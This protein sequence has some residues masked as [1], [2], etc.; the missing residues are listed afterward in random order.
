[1]KIS[2]I[3]FNL[4]K[5]GKKQE[6]LTTKP[7]ITFEGNKNEAAKKAGAILGIPLVLT[8]L[9]GC[10]GGGANQPS[11]A[12]TSTAT[13][14]NETQDVNTNTSKEDEATSLGNKYD[15]MKTNGA[16]LLTADGKIILSDVGFHS[17]PISEFYLT[18]VVGQQKLHP[19][20]D[21]TRNDEGTI[22]VTISNKETN[23]DNESG[24]TLNEIIE[25]VYSEALSQYKDEQERATIKNK[26][27]DE[28]I[29]ANPSLSAYI[30]EELGRDVESYEEIGN[31]D[32]YKG[33]SSVDEYLDTRLLTMPTTIVYQKQGVETKETDYSTSFTNYT[34]KTQIAS[35][36]KDSDDLL[37]GEYKSF[38]D[39]VYGVY[40]KDISNEA[41]R[42]IVYAIVNSPANAYEFEYALDQMN[43]NEIIRTGNITDINRTLDENTN[44]LMVGLEMPNITTLRVNSKNADNNKVNKNAIIYQI[45]PAALTEGEND[46]VITLTDLTGDK[47]LSGDVFALKDVLQFYSSPDGNGRFAYIEDGKTILNDDVNYVEEFANQIMKQVVYA[48]IDLFATPYAIGDKVYEYGVFDV[49]KGYDTKDKS[50]DEIIKNSTIN[51]SRMNKFSFIDENGEMKYENGT[52]LNLPQFNYRLNLCAPKATTPTPVPTTE[53]TTVPTTEPTTVPTTEPTTC[54]TTEPTTCPTTEPTTCPTTEPTTCP[55]TEPTTC[56][57]TEPTTCPT[58]EPTTVPT[59]EPTTCPTTEPTTCPTTEPTTCPTTEPTTCPTTEPTTVPT[60]EPTTCPTTEPTTVPTTEPTTCPTTEPTTCPTTEPTTCPT[61]EPTTV[62]TTEPTTVP[63]T[64]PTTCP[65]IPTEPTEPEDPPTIPTTIPTTEPT[66]VPTTVPTTEPTTV[67]TTEPTTVPTTVPSSK[68]TLPTLPTATPIDPDEPT[69]EPTTCPTTMPTEEP[70]TEERPTIP[71]TVEPPTTEPSCTVPTSEIEPTTCPTTNPTVEPTTEE[72]P[73]I[74]TSEIEPPCTVPTTEPTTVPTTEPTTVPTTEPTTVPT[75]E[76]TTVPTT[77]PT[78]VPTTEPTTVPTTE[79]TSCA[80][81]VPVVNPEEE[82][83]PTIPTSKPTES[84]TIPTTEPTTVPTTEPTT[85]EEKPSIP[86]TVPTTAP[87]TEPTTEPTTVP[88]TEPTTAPTTAPTTEPTSCPTTKPDIDVEEEER[89]NFTPSTDVEIDVP[90]QEEYKD[91]VVTPV[92][93]N[94]EPATEEAKVETPKAEEPKY[95][96]PKYEEPKYEEPK[97]EEPKYEEP[98]YE[99]NKADDVVVE[100][101]TTFIS[102]MISRSY[103]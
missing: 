24:N 67:P 83:K 63:T 39:M 103:K 100:E 77:E 44:K 64:E 52:Q 51:E 92:L 93:E 14:T 28:I 20:K 88:T 29:Q 85:E 18:N 4:P 40:G 26:M 32:L 99:E 79:P 94:K 17:L 86:T 82:E 49:N 75:T 33:K 45:S 97:Y 47:K 25:E 70:T 60:T 62:P 35:V 21:L 10:L 90:K 1:M 19:N 59:T 69:T 68:P 80:T 57:T 71:S 96:E 46:K 30:N 6:E 13:N 48:N 36:I 76:P 61:T 102:K 7:S 12:P 16:I 27:I 72:R 11:T 98:K 74:P 37:D 50:L 81:D 55:T 54:P 89:P 22:I 43:F 66:T 42:D 34:P 2:R 73:T 101:P 84:T 87:T 31:L 15:N 8:S 78:T 38:S 53:P 65:P 41:Y 95:E 58:T 23:K 3:S 9:T 5:I 91:E 56:P